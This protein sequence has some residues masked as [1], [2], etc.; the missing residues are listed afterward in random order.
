[1]V[2]AVRKK[3]IKKNISHGQ[4]HVKSTFNNT[5]I[6]ITD[7]TGNVITWASS[8][9]SGFKGSR[10]STPYASQIAA[11]IA[12]EKAREHGVEKIDIFVKG[13]GSGRD[14]AIRSLNASGLYVN[15]I[16]DVTP[17]P[18]NGCRPRKPRKV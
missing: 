9:A 15:S 14:S 8:G 10:K 1:M 12:V 11:E 13:I 17:V 7:E 2:K 18:H 3:K 5:V 6:T 16:K 4:A